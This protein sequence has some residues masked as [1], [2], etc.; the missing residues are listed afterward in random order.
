MNSSSGIYLR[1]L[2]SRRHAGKQGNDDS[3]CQD[4]NDTNDTKDGTETEQNQ[5]EVKRRQKMRVQ[6]RGVRL[7]PVNM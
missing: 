4:A 1:W 2:T 5:K 6:E 7:F 3:V